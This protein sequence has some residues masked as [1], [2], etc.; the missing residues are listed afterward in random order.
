MAQCGWRCTVTAEQLLPLPSFDQPG[1]YWLDGPC[2]AWCDN[3]HADTDFVDDRRHMS[4]WSAH[5]VLTTEEPS[6]YEHKPSEGI[7]WISPFELVLW[8]DQHVQHAAPRVILH[9]VCRRIDELHLTAAEAY[10]LADSLI[11]GADLAT[12]NAEVLALPAAKMG[13]AS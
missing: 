8:L 4:H 12:A 2:P 3:P 10:Q 5:I 6:I 13:S 9:E 11:R 1:P 7:P